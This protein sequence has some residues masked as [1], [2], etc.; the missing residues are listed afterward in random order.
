MNNYKVTSMKKLI[1]YCAIF[2]ILFSASCKKDF[3]DVPDKTTLLREAYVVDLKTTGDFLNGVYVQL[4][5]Y[6]YYGYHIIYPELVADNIKP[7]RSNVLPD[8]YT[9]NQLPN[10]ASPITMN[11]RAKNL[12]SC[13]FT[14]YRVIRDCNFV[15]EN[16]DKYRAEN[17]AKADDIKGQALALRALIHSVLV[18]VY[19]QAPNFTADASH[20]GV[21][22]VNVHD[23]SQPVSRQTVAQVYDMIVADLNNALGL[24]S[25]D[26][27]NKGYINRNAVTALLAR[28][29]LARGN[30]Q[31]AKNMA[32]Q[33]SK[34]VPIMTGADYPSKLYTVGEI[35]ALFQLPPAT[36]GAPDGGGE[37]FTSFAGYYFGGAQ[38]IFRATAD[39]AL[40]LTESA[41][42]VRSTWVTL[43][44][45]NYD[46]TKF[47]VDQVPG[48]WSPEA[49]Y[50]QT[51]FRSSEMYLVAA[52]AYAQL[53]NADSARYYLDAIRMRADNTLTPG[54]E[55]G[56]ALLEAIYE[57]RRKELSFEGFRMFDLQRWKKSVERNDASNPNAKSLPYPANKAI[58]PIPLQDVQLSGLSQNTGY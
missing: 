32:V 44:G 23:W 9:W 34:A 20:P 15:V 28:V 26:A 35:E 7:T 41:T 6:F 12:N 16:V 31:Q 29:H 51:V 3:L 21:P 52:E 13:W 19:A 57:E 22:Y 1:I 48:I 27:D 24:L 33:V 54:A 40:L 14:G 8:L 5:W 11:S 58:A 46:I 47:P 56:T 50:Y 42:D 53:N 10:D 39:V 18:N 49:S 55:T 36:P 38:K 17:P 25:A 2:I 4:G 45:S 43:N 30:W 37:Y